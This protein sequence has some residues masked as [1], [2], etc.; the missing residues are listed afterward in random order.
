GGFGS[1][2]DSGWALS[3]PIDRVQEAFH[4]EPITPAKVSEAIRSA[5]AEGWCPRD[6]AAPRL[7]E[8]IDGSRLVQC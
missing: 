6:P 3:A 7:F 1:D 8:L 4:L 5:L 2:C